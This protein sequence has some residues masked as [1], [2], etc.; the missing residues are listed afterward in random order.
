[1]VVWA[2]CAIWAYEGDFGH[3]RVSVRF[4]VIAS[5]IP[6]RHL[7]AARLRGLEAS[8]LSDLQIL[9]TEKR[10]SIK[11]IPFGMNFKIVIMLWRPK[12]P[13]QTLRIRINYRYVFNII[14]ISCQKRFIIK[15]I[16]FGMDF[17]I[18]IMLWRPKGPN[19]TLRIRIRYRY[20]FTT[21]L[22]SCQSCRLH[23][24]VM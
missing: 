16:P 14:P 11:T 13:N 5:R 7:E 18:F 8:R 22:T 4:I 15:T 20:V 6:P 10:F 17:K 24:E 1:M 9:L 12:G 21:L 2:T 3:T 23:L 19:Q